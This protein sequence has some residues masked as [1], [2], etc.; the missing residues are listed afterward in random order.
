M[1]VA[2]ISSATV[3]ALAVLYCFA[4]SQRARRAARADEDHRLAEIRLE[5]LRKAQAREA[6]IDSAAPTTEFLNTAP[7]LSS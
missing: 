5:L 3:I 2:L 4:P 6:A 1:L 7:R